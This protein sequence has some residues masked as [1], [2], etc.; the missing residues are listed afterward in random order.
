MIAEHID[1]IKYP[2]N[3]LDKFEMLANFHTLSIENWFGDDEIILWIK[4]K[5]KMHFYSEEKGLKLFI[6][7]GI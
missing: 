5:I 1:L 6:K 4:K 2:L 3:K 7:K